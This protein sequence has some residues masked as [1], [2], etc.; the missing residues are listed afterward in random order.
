MGNLPGW[1]RHIRA[2][3]RLGL[4]LLGFH[5]LVAPT[6]MVLRDTW[7]AAGYLQ[8]WM[9]TPVNNL[10]YLTGIRLE[11]I[12]RWAIAHTSL[13]VPRVVLFFEAAVYVV[14]GGIFYFAVGFA[15]GAT[16]SKLRALFKGKGSSAQLPQRGS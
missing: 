8:R 1:S 12:A 16:G 11:P 15:M 13:S 10:S 3:L 6:L 14:L 4:L 2:G 5:S 9:D 7:P